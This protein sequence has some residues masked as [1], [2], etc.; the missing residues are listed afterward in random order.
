MLNRHEICVRLGA[1]SL[2]GLTGCAGVDPRGDYR[3]VDDYVSTSTGIL[4]PERPADSEAVR[5]IIA[6]RLANGLSAD[7]AMALCIL[8][9]P[10]VRAAY[11]SV[12][13]ARADVVQ[14][15]LFQNPSMSLALRLPDGGGLSNLELSVAQNI[16]DLWLIP[17]RKRTAQAELQRR[18]VEVAR[19]VGESVLQARSLYFAAVASDREREV[20][21]ENRDLAQRI[22]DVA[23]ARQSAGV[24]NEIDVNL[25]R[26]EWMQTEINVQQS[27]LLAFEARRRLAEQI[28]LAV[29]PDALTLSDTLA[30]PRALQCSDAELL[31]A[32]ALSRLDLV[33][34]DWIVQ[35]AAAR[36]EQERRSVVQNVELGVSFERSDRGRRGDRPW[37]ADTLWA[38]AEAGQLSAPSLRPREKLPTNTVIGP[39]LSFELPLFDQNQAQ[40]ARADYL[41]QAAEADRD[42]LLLEATQAT[43]SALRKAQVAARL[44]SFYSDDFLP[45]AQHNLD[46]TREAYR[47]GQISILEVLESQKFLLGAR[48]RHVELLRD[49]VVALIE[50]ERAVGLPLD[51]IAHAGAT[52]TPDQNQ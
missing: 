10:R 8:S 17:V 6:E 23:L 26:G 19:I 46:L 13:V 25:A 49:S 34:A 48:G 32:A 7:D 15:G 39:T 18:T 4:A 36:V 16:A 22:V 3:R 37:L 20:A 5:T 27:E 11:L 52:E 33:A 47:V 21:R 14:A 50:L 31:R 41:L 24:G 44:V 9:N 12:G 43:R 28:G 42:A 30:A 45:L 29:A 38:S 1:L 40:I 51:R 35:A 2:A